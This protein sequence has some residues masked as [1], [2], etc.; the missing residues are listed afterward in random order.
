MASE[1][2]REIEVAMKRLA[3]AKSQVS[4]ASKNMQSVEEMIA[5]NM[6]SVKEMNAKMRENA[7]SQLETAQKECKEAD[8]MLKDAEKRWEVIE[9]ESLFVVEGSGVSEVNGIYIR[10][11]ESCYGSPVFTKEELRQQWLGETVTFQVYR[12]NVQQHEYWYIGISGSHSFY[13]ASLGDNPN[14]PPKDGWERIGHGMDP[15]PKLIY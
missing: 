7:Q 10:T 14:I 13:R 6:Q 5:K 2:S 3:A 11:P 1:G 12:R 8:A 9:I 15:A 4:A